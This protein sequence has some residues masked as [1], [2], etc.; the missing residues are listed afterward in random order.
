MKRKLLLILTAITIFFTSSQ[1]VFAY[2]S[3]TTIKDFEESVFGSNEYKS[4]RHT[5]STV[6]STTTAL[7]NMIIG[8]TTCAANVSPETNRGAVGF[9]ASAIGDIYSK[10][11]ASTAYYFADL[12]ERLNITQP[13]YA[14]GIGF[15]GLSPLLDLWKYIRNIAYMFFVVVF[16]IIGFAIMFRAKISPQTVVT[17][18]SAIPKIV[19]AL[20]LVSFSYAIVG[21]IIDLMYLLIAIVINIFASSGIITLGD[22]ALAIYTGMNFWNLLKE[23]FSSGYEGITSNLTGILAGGISSLITGGIGA[24]LFGPIGGLAV[25]LPAL[26][27]SIVLLI[28]VFRIFFSLLSAYINI[29]ISLLVAPIQ[30][31]ISAI[32][33]QNTFSSWMKNLLSNIVVF[34]TVVAMLLL[35]KTFAEVTSKGLWAPPIIGGGDAETG[36]IMGG[37]LAL[38]VLLLIPKA[39]DIVKSL[40]EGK[41]FAYGTAINQAVVAPATTA[42]NLG[43]GIAKSAQ[44]GLLKGVSS[45]AGEVIEERRKIKRSEEAAGSVGKDVASGVMEAENRP[46]PSNK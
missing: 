31:M 9:F 29:I 26:I 45:K 11:P 42:F 28:A 8:C 36:N 4:E 7:L 23:V 18:Q 10:K 5:Y 35:S 46:R 16:L 1:A 14:Q 15:S 43:E 25:V 34:P 21:L 22:D 38:G 39:L 40:F 44:G 2:E 32:P 41:P 27:I 37:L 19:V 17:I 12:G 6:N 33:G 30:L 13:A 24:G 20:I 3:G